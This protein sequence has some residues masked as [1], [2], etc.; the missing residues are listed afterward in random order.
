MENA[1]ISEKK[2]NKKKIIIFGI[3]A[4][5]LIGFAVWYF[6]WP[7]LNM[8]TV[9]SLIADA[10]KTYSDPA[11][12]ETILLQGVKEIRWN[13]NLYLMAKDYAANQSMAIEQVIV[14]S[15]VSMAKQYQYIS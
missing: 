12:V 1:P 9:K 14:D 4:I 11:G 13:R 15:A 7:R 6:F 10:S 5:A 8:T 2:S 3:L